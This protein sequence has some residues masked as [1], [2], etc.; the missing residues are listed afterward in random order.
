MFNRSGMSGASGLSCVAVLD[1]WMEMGLD[2]P[3]V[4][5]LENPLGCLVSHVRCAIWGYGANLI[6]THLRFASITPSVFENF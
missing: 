1:D 5:S 2:L 4:I 6:Y 3:S